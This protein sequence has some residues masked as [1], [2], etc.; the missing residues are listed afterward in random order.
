MDIWTISPDGN[1]A[2]RLTS[3]AGSNENPVWSPDGRFLAFMSTRNGP[4]EIYIMG[5]DGSNPRRI[6][7]S[8]GNAMPY[9]SDY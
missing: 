4:P 1:A 9:W 2:V 3:G 8:G 5:A 7:F 6:S